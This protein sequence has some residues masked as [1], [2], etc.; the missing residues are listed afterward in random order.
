MAKRGFRKKFSRRNG[1][2]TL[3]VAVIAGFGPLTVNT[4]R[5]PGGWDRKLWMFT[6]AMTG[7]DTDTQ[8]FWWPNM[9]K[10]AI[11]IMMGALVHWVAGKVGI[12]RALSRSGIPV[13]R[14]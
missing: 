1:K 7:Y 2:F 12:N 13:L 10:G 14:V 11:P 6:Q 3:P 4:L 9:K 8:Q 5:T